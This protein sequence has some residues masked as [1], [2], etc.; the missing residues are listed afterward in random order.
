M[1]LSTSVHPEIKRLDFTYDLKLKRWSGDVQYPTNTVGGFNGTHGAARITFEITSSWNNPNEPPKISPPSP[2]PTSE[3]SI[4][5][6]SSEEIISKI[7]KNEDGIIKTYHALEDPMSNGVIDQP[8][9]K[10][11]LSGKGSSDNNDASLTAKFPWFFGKDVATFRAP[12]DP[13]FPLQAFT[14]TY[15]F[16]VTCENKEL[17]AKT[18]SFNQ[19]S[20]NREIDNIVDSPFKFSLSKGRCVDF[21]IDANGN[22]KISRSDTSNQKS[23]LEQ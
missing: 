5:S 18:E 10:I 17:V 22:I 3:P 2:I 16:K 4:Q 19:D 6:V 13:C 8:N 15:D 20:G 21:T 11:Q 1:I 14:I 9:D 7:K 23:R 12:I